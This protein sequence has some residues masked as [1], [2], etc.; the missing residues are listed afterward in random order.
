MPEETECI[1]CG[2]PVVA[3]ETPKSIFGQR[4]TGFIKMLFFASAAMTIASLFFDATPS[5]AKCITC[6]LVLLCV[7]SSAE[8]MQERKK[9]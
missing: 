4:F 3:R 7:K 1:A 2:A 5:F 6:T 9:L 8:Q